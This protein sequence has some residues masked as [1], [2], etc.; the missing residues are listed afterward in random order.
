[1]L[2]FL[3]LSALL[4][5]IVR[6]NIKPDDHRIAWRK[7]LSSR[8]LI[9]DVWEPRTRS[10]ETVIAVH[11]ATLNGKDDHRL[12]A[13]A[14]SLAASG[15]R[16]VVPT[17]VGLS[18]IQFVATDADDLAALAAE[19]ANTYAPPIMVG[20]SFG[21]TCALLAAA[22]AG[23]SVRYVLSFGAAYSYEALFNELHSW[24]RTPPTNTRERKERL[25]ANLIMAFR[26]ARDIGLE[27]NIES[28][29]SPLRRFCEGL[30]N[31]EADTLECW[32]E[33]FEPLKPFE[34]AYRGVDRLALNA[35]SPAGQLKGL[36][37]GTGI[38]HDPNDILVSPRHAKLLAQE[39]QAL[40]NG[41]KHR[42]LVTS[43]LEHVDLG[44]FNFA[45]LGK[46]VRIL[47]PLVSTSNQKETNA[48]K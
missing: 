18:R 26:S 29:A 7:F 12:Q 21:G 5:R 37:C 48:T 15:I 8:G 4:N 14:R 17:M 36:T 30:P 10:L 39:L 6:G 2:H 3:R 32:L 25:Y 31:A 19:L 13:F 33:S 11:G 46:L 38:V 20:F 42:L 34:A 22:K 28:V 44:K 27:N 43:L 45:D 47:E 16:C 24:W 1:M 23:H 9:C 41:E 35:A 40:H